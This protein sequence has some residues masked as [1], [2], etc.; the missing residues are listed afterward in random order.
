M[1][2]SQKTKQ[3]KKQKQYC[4]MFSKDFDN[5]PYQKKERKKENDLSYQKALPEHRGPLPG[6]LWPL[7]RW[8]LLDSQSIDFPRMHHCRPACPPGQ[9]A[10]LG[11]RVSCRRQSCD[12][13]HLK[14]L[15][16][17]ASWSSRIWGLPPSFSLLFCGLCHRA[18]KRDDGRVL[19]SDP[20]PP[21]L[22]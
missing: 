1:P 4:N 11:Q 5:G 19:C 22:P 8:Y 7:E 17:P 18:G 14:Y 3:T 6:P 9:M 21:S 2:W 12:L 16:H 20:G 13:H 10:L 15:D